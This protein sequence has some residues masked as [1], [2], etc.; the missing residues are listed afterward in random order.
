MR[1]IADA[2]V[3]TLVTIVIEELLLSQDTPAGSF[4][5]VCL[6]Q[7]QASKKV[8]Y[9]LL[10]YLSRIF[11]NTL[12]LEVTQANQVVSAVAG[13][14]D[15]VVQDDQGRKMHLVNWCCSPSG[16]GLGDGI[17]IR[18]AVVAV[19]AKDRELLATVLEKSL[20]Q[21]GDQLYIK[22][23]AILQQEGEY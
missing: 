9:M 8:I 13:L 21:F 6:H 7:P 4:S 22:H 14:I 18:R 2:S 19:L 11:L 10:D 1:N 17:G 16:A 23:T 12:D 15:S 5:K 20:N 3:E